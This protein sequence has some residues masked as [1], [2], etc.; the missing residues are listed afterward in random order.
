MRPPENE[1]DSEQ[2]ESLLDEEEQ[3]LLDRPDVP[4]DVK[5]ELTERIERR[6]EA[7]TREET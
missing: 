7:D 6:H 3:K 4:D 5:S 2:I 1:P